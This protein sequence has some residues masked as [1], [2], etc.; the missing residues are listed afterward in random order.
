MRI[1]KF[2]FGKAFFDGIGVQKKRHEIKI[3]QWR[4]WG[5]RLTF[6]YLVLI[7]AF[8]TLSTRLFHLTIVR[9]A[10]NRALSEENRTRVSIIHAPRGIIFDR[11]G[12]PLVQ[13]AEA[14]RVIGPCDTSCQAELWLKSD[15]E[16]NPEHK[17]MI[18]EQDSIRQ[19]IYP[20]ETAHILGYL[21]EIA[22][23][24]IQNPQYVYQDYLLGDKLGRAGMEMIFEK[25][26]RG[27]D[28]KE[29]IEVDAQG[30]ALRSLGKIDSIK[31]EDLYTS[32]DIDLQKRAYEALGEHMG[33]VVVSKTKTGEILALVSTPS[34]DPNKINS[35]ISDTD[36]KKLASADQPMFNRAISGVYPPGS[37]FKPLNA[38]AGLEA[39]KISAATLIE[40]TGR[41]E[42]GA[43]SFGNW[44]FTQ[45][46]KVEGKVD[47]VRALA[48]SNDIYFYKLGE[49]VGVETIATWG[50][51]LKFGTK[52]G[53]ELPHEAEGI[54]PDPAWRM[55]V[56]GTSWYLGDTYHLSIGQGDLL[57]TPLQV[58]LLTSTIANKGIWCPPTLLKLDATT[59]SKSASTKCEDMKIKVA[60]LEVVT[61]GMRRACTPDKGWGYQGT[62]WPLFDLVIEKSEKE[63]EDAK[64]ISLPLACKTGTAEF[65]NPEGKTHAW[66]TAFA[67]LDYSDATVSAI[68]GEPEI[69]VTVVVEQGGEGS[70][71]AAPIAKQL[72]QEWFGR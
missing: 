25:K 72:L 23:E 16:K 7:I 6:F 48:R 20:Y 29:L 35:G 11:M 24:E 36:F 30:G 65:G 19:L 58:N 31:G 52:S 44:Y 39:E 53:I 10:E 60:T 18:W 28:G 63:G 69:A 54:M 46:G 2:K 14:A 47:M 4:G 57:T 17:K 12:K 68:T 5:A 27:V 33:A 9:G 40:D 26:L 41:L 67:P 42:V 32:I 70:S 21:G 3:G 13:N 8:F 61:E 45:Y 55:K 64:K 1:R 56:R 49:M 43:F 50:K 15:L 38:I 62:G 37:V 22:E 71:V 51:K 59:L 66:F 34:F